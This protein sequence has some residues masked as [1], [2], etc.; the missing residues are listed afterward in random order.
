MTFDQEIAAAFGAG[1]AAWP[2]ASHSLESFAAHVRALGVD[3]AD[4]VARASDLF[5]AS[6]C[7][8][9]DPAALRAFERAFIAGVDV[10]AARVGLPRQLLDELRQRVR[11]KLL[12]GEAPAI[13]RYRGR[14]PLMVWV[15]VTAARVAADVAAAASVPE[16][17]PDTEMLDLLVSADTSPELEA[18]KARY[19]ERFRAALEASLAELTA[20]EKTLL[21]LHFIDG[22]NIDCIGAIY[23]VH[24]AT[25]ARWLVAIRARVFARLNERF[26]SSVG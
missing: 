23:R 15:L 26:A 13:G 24:R 6:A 8:E 18:V 1:R 10:V 2:E 5:L 4:L 7:A 12:V 22:L 3:D 21:S 14:G 20:R 11:V 16:S 19:R 17:A 9:G 25:V